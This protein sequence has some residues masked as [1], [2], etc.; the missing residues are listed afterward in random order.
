MQ[1]NNYHQS[2]KKPMYLRMIRK[3]MGSNPYPS[4]ILM[5]DAML[6][7]P[8]LRIPM[9]AMADCLK[10]NFEDCQPKSSLDKMK[11]HTDLELS[12]LDI[13]WVGFTDL[14]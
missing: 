3:H 9:D 10:A 2:I 4:A 12:L 1:F 6:S 13:T 11:L 5:F 8:V 7:K 14:G